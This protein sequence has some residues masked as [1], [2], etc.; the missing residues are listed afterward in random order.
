MLIKFSCNNC[1]N[2]ISKFYKEFKDVPPFLDCGACGIGKLE[3][4]L[5]IPSSMS[6]EVFDNGIMERKVVLKKA[7]VDKQESKVETEIHGVDKE[8]A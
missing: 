4:L 2:S 7:V 8:N 3:R 1:N 6:E 5:S